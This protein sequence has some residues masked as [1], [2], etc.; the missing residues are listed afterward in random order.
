MSA[1]EELRVV[2][3]I[4]GEAE[5]HFVL[6]PEPGSD[7]GIK[8]TQGFGWGPFFGSVSSLDCVSISGAELVL[9]SLLLVILSPSLTLWF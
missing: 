7:I 5:L 6:K 8:S 1:V 9:P 3:I 2:D 4:E